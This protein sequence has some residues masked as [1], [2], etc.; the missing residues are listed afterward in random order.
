[1]DNMESGH[2]KRLP[3]LYHLRHRAGRQ[4]R[5][6]VTQDER[7]SSWEEKDE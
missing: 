6:T 3:A 1:M 7:L 5:D 4:G 2:K